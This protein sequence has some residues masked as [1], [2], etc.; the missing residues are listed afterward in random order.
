MKTPFHLWI[1][2]VLALLWSL[3]GAADYTLTE[4]DHPAYMAQFTPDQVAYS[5]SFPAWVVA[6]R[7]TA[8]WAGVLGALLLLRRSGGAPLVFALSLAAMIVTDIYSFALAEVTM[9]DVF[10]P[11][12]L[13][14]SGL[15][16]VIGVA[17]LLY[18]RWMRQRG[19]LG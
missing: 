18:A 8:V 11:G 10:G 12:A 15:I 6:A 16:M 19:Y 4:L 5:H 13:W 9:T 3:A 2:G 7:A 14:F 1:I 17:L